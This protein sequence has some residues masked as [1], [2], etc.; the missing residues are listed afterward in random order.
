M[1]LARVIGTVVSTRKD[2]ALVGFKLLVVQIED[3]CDGGD[4]E[5]LV[6]VDTVGAGVGEQVLVTRGSAAR[7]TLPIAAPTDAAIVG[8]IDTVDLK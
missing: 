5:R 6:A 1:Q 8:I 4:N 2:D 3:P 7:L